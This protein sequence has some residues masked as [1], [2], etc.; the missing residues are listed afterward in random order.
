MGERV[1]ELL[2]KYRPVAFER[3]ELVFA[4]PWPLAAVLAVGGL[5]LAAGIAGYVRPRHALPRR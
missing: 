4:P 5:V 3:G 1:F 2:F